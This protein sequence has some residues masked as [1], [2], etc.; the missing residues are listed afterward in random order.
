MWFFQRPKVVAFVWTANVSVRWWSWSLSATMSFHIERSISTMSGLHSRRP[1]PSATI[2]VRGCRLPAL[3]GLK[4]F[5]A[6]STG[7]LST[8]HSL[9]PQSSAT[10]GVRGCRLPAIKGLKPSAA[11]STG[12]FDQALRPQSSATIGVRGCRLR[13]IKALQTL[14]GS[15][16]QALRP[17]PSPEVTISAWPWRRL[18]WEILMLTSIDQWQRRTGVRRCSAS[19]HSP[20][21]IT[22]YHL[23][24]VGGLEHVLFFH[25]LGIIIP[26][27][28][29]QRGWSH[30]PG[31]HW[32]VWTV[33]Q[34][35]HRISRSLIMSPGQNFQ[36]KSWGF[37]PR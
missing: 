31:Y 17:Q 36:G 26:T 7:R 32:N 14:R 10:F 21:L 11:A 29:F 8:R 37:R 23:I 1:Q 20:K 4:R 33:S 18:I 6:A 34:W 16:D 15:F 22:W 25:I 12:S 13:A 19:D 24:L 30:Q 28:M 9:R 3:K 27:N 2:G 35:Q 5:A